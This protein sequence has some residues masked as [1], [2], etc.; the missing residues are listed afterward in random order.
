MARSS[1]TWGTHR[2]TTNMPA[3]TTNIT[4][5]VRPSPGSTTLVSHA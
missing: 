2:A 3:M 5:R 4:T 1:N